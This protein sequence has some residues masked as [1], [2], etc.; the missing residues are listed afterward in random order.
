MHMLRGRG[1]LTWRLLRR[2]RQRQGC[3]AGQVNAHVCQRTRCAMPCADVA[4]GATGPCRRC[5]SQ[6]SWACPD[7][8]CFCVWFR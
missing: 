6:S 4:W 2:S 5:L 8:E 7:D 3:A 1:V